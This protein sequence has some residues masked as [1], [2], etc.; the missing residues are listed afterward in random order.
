MDEQYT[1]RTRKRL[2]AAVF[3]WVRKFGIDVGRHPADREKVNREAVARVAVLEEAL[4]EFGRHKSDCDIWAGRYRVIDPKRKCTCGLVAA[5]TDRKTEE[6]KR[7]RSFE[8]S[9]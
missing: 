1:A 9:R 2:Q 8:R 6:A 7:W 4:E 5:L 3:A